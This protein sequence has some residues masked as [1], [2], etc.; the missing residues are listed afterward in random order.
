MVK[1]WDAD[2][3]DIDNIIDGR[4]HKSHWEKGLETLKSLNRN[5]V[6]EKLQII[7]KP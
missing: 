4:N 1:T 7:A 3:F 2:S 6:T 5:T